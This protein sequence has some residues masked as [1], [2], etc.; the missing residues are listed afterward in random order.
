MVRKKF[1]MVVLIFPLLLI[2]LSWFYLVNPVVVKNNPSE[3]VPIPPESMIRMREDVL[4]L[5]E[6]TVNRNY[7][8]TKAL[9]QSAEYIFSQFEKAG[10]QAQYQEFTAHGFGYKNIIACTSAAAGERIV[11][12]AHYDVYNEQPGADDNASGVAGLLELARWIKIKNP[13]LPYPVELVAFALEEP[14]YFK[15]NLM[16]SAIHA[17]DLADRKV[18]VKI[19]ICFDMIGYFSEKKGSQQFPI[20]LLKLFYPSQGNFI[21][22]VGK[23]G[24]WNLVR[25]VKKQMIKGSA[26]EVRSINAP[27]FLPGIDFSDH[28][29]Y[30]NYGYPAVMITDTALFRNPNYHKKTDT[31]ET[32]DFKKMEQVMQAIYYLIVHYK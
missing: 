28:L 17:K 6:K 2:A 21:T 22:V 12:G 1:L 16:G 7:A 10:Y 3:F 11:I 31:I 14:P 4:F 19:M 26:I 20:L 29:N 9:N 8:N 18:P 24:Q 27:R 13:A 32:L 25:K 5:T 23:T 15:T 30:W